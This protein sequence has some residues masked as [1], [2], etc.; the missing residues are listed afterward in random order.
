MRSFL[1]VSLLASVLTSSVTI[2]AQD[3]CDKQ[4]VVS[5]VNLLAAQLSPGEQATIKAQLIGRCFDE[6]QLGELVGRVR[7]TLQTLGY[8][9]ATLS[10]P[11]I[12]IGE[13]SRHP[14]PASLS[15]A[16]AEGARYK[17]REVV[18]TGFKAVPGENIVSISQ[19][20]PEDILDTSKVRATVE[21]VRKL[22]AASGYPV[23]SII[24]QIEAHEAGH[25]VAV[26]F[27]VVEGPQSP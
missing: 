21:A 6:Q 10:E 24:P 7:D 13:V 5:E 1:V 9:R 19:I 18:W 20:R 11:T 23:A 15:F 25:W 2:T 22:Y 26:Y 8:F 4:Y 27:S 17:V 12:T 3:S 14:N 16:V